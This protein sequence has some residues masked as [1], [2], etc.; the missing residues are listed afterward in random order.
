ML[1]LDQ[2][3]KMSSTIKIMALLIA[4]KKGYIYANLL[5][6]ACNVH[7]TTA[8]K[9]LHE[10]EKDGILCKRKMPGRLIAYEVKKSKK[11]DIQTYVKFVKKSI[12]HSYLN[13]Y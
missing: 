10:L 5:S 13:E 1:S 3:V 11:K 6:K 7:I 9:H 12:D 8:C 2:F 4:N